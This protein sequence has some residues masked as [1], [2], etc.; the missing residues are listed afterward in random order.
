MQ[1]KYLRIVSAAI[2]LADEEGNVQK[3][4]EKRNQNAITILKQRGEYILLRVE[5]E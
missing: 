4:A 3:L 2:D 1:E 5:S